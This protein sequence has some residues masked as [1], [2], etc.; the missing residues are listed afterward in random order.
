MKNPTFLFVKLNARMNANLYHSKNILQRRDNFET[1]LFW[2]KNK[3]EKNLQTFFAKIGFGHFFC[4]FW[5]F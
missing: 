2:M 4:P 5:E 1:V 3:K